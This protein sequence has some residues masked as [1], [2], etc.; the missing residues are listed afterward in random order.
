MDLNCELPRDLV[1]VGDL[2]EL[3]QSHAEAVKCIVTDAA[4][5]TFYEEEGIPVQVK[6]T[7][8]ACRRYEHGSVHSHSPVLLQLRR[9]AR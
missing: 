7:A 1:K 8:T 2:A 9:R 4:A 3:Y 6:I 5:G